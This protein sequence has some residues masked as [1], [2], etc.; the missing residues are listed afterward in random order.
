MTG[1]SPRTIARLLAL[2]GTWWAVLLAGA[3][4][5]GAR[6]TGE[7]LHRIFGMLL[8]FGL[9]YAVWAGWILR[10]FVPM[11]RNCRIAIWIG[12]IVYN[13]GWFLL[14]LC[15]RGRM[16]PLIAGW[17]AAAAF[18]SLVALTQAVHSAEAKKES[19]ER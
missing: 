11:S 1:N 18:L 14:L 13:L 6:S 16:P 9:G 15:N 3:F 19:P 10:G 17:W 4:F 2:G 7:M 12:S 5:P 8:Y